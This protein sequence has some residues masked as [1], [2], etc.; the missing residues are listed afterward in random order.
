MTLIETLIAL[1]IIGFFLF[2]FSQVFL[3]SYYAWGR[4]MNTYQTAHTID[5]IAK[6]FKIECAKKDRNME[7]WKR[8]V[9][10]AKELEHYEITEYWQDG[11]LR[12]LKASCIISGEVIEIIGLCT[13]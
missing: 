5:F 12:A 2:G 13:P 8:T 9:S 10:T 7:N 4:A 6:S 11:V 1:I 3:P